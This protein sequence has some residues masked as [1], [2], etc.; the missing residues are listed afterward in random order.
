MKRFFKN[1]ILFLLMTVF[2]VSLCACQAPETPDTVPQNPIPQPQPEPEPEPQPP[3]LGWM[4][5][6][7]NRY[8]YATEDVMSTGWTEIDGVTY[9]FRHDGILATGAVEIDGQ[10]HFFSSQGIEFLMVNPW[11]SA[12]EGYAPEVMTI[13]G[14]WLKCNVVCHDAL[15]E[16]LQACRDAGLSPY[17]NSA[18]RTHGDQIWLFQNKINRLME[19]GYTEEDAKVLAA[20]VV[21]IP[22]TSEHEL[23]LAFD[24][25]D[26]SYK[27]LDSDQESTNVQ[28]WLME[29][30]WKYG[31]ILRYPNQ[32]TEL[33]GIIYE[34]WHYRYIGKEIAKEL[35]ESG[36]CLEEYIQ[37]LTLE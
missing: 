10:T 37:S 6:G 23:G 35:Y 29:N 25:V 36:L 2:L 20:T 21:A 15:Q 27:D 8:Y 12:P 26:E 31:F 1:S 18:Y 7:G 33:T 22:G 24:I 5:I 3:K 17:I 19:E 14:H 9:Y 13:D 30:S 11:N 16:M 34:P 28:Q 4:V 32:K